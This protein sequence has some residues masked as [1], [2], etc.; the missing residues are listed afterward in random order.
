MVVLT[1]AVGRSSRQQPCVRECTTRGCVVVS[2]RTASCR[3]HEAASNPGML[4]Q[5]PSTLTPGQHGSLLPCPSCHWPRRW[6]CAAPRPPPPPRPR[7]RGSIHPL[8]LCPDAPTLLLPS[9][10]LPP[11]GDEADLR[12][13][14]ELR[15][16]A[17]GQ[18]IPIVTTLAGAK[19][20]TA[21]LRAIRAGPLLQIPLQVSQPAWGLGHLCLWRVMAG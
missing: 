5:R 13:G 1:A 19:A 21:A 16:L 11:S 3:A 9:A 17:L 8:I 14:K 12:D 6:P 10:S 7:T 18:S 15:R 20:T 4:A 2:R